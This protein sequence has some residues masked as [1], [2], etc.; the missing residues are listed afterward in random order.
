[1]SV[2]K[3]KLESRTILD[4]SRSKI[5]KNYIKNSLRSVKLSD[6][7]LYENTITYINNE[8]KIGMYNIRLHFIDRAPIYQD[9]RPLKDCGKFN[10]NI[11]EAKSE[12]DINLSRDKRFKDQYWLGDES[13][14][15][16]TLTDVIMYCSRLNDLKP[17][18]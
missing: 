5:S 7:N 13:M 6:F 3:G 10:I 15:I 1:M 14:K 2:G 9:K 11:R 8:I 18:L 17:F 16:N 12:E 4:F